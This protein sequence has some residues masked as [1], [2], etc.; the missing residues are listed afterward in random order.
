[1]TVKLLPAESK[2]IFM[3]TAYSKFTFDSDVDVG[4]PTVMGPPDYKSQHFY[5]KMCVSF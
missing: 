2:D 5:S 1:M 4:A 3:L